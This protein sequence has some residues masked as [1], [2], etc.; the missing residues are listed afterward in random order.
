MD[1][2]NKYKFR[3]T[4]FI[5]YLS[6]APAII[7]FGLSSIFILFLLHVMHFSI[8]L[9][10]QT[11]SFYFGGMYLISIAIGY[12]SDKYLSKSSALILGY[13]L[14]IISQIFLA[15][16]SSL[17]VQSN[18]I[19][20]S[21]F[22]NLQTS[23]FFTGLVILAVGLSFT[24]I[25]TPTIINS[26]NDTD[27][28]EEAF[29]IF[30]PIMNIGVLIGPIL[31]TFIVGS[32][33]YYLY[34]LC[35][36]LFAVILGIAL[37]IFSL[38]KNKFLVDNNGNVMEEHSHQEEVNAKKSITD[39][40]NSLQP[41]QKDRIQVFMI[42]LVI[43]ILYRISYAQSSVSLVFFIDKYIN[44]DLGFFVIPVQLFF[45]LN[46]LFIL[47][48]SPLLLLFNKK[49]EEKN[50]EFGIIKKSVASLLFLSLGFL[51]LSGLGYCMDNNLTSDVGFYW[52]IIYELLIAISELLFIV[53]SY[54]LVSFLTPE[55]YY[56]FFFS[57]FLFTRSISSFLSGEIAELFPKKLIPTAL[58]LIVDGIMDFYI[59]F[60]VLTL[61]TAFVIYHYRN[62]L[63]GK[64]HIEEFNNE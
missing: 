3:G 13:I 2:K 17:Y 51:I 8:P 56:P 34:Q 4:H 37:L 44:R 10:S 38:F 24:N 35:F 20:T 21:Y 15:F 5:S 40:Y 46:P 12:I 28:K 29:S 22:F 6:I 64:I 62:Y 25:I 57:L 19:Y 23:I 26:I 14:M 58:T 32:D 27:S 30:Y 53:S 33:D 9:S 1:T 43:I 45:V 48:L 49:I 16:S 41:F 59:I 39:L 18:E 60:V 50:I 55:E 31:T 54:S 63:N 36:S 11:Y 42:L 47:I 61:V 52:I 7:E